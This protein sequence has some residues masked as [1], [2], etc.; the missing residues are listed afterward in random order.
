MVSE[1]EPKITVFSGTVARSS[2]K[3]LDQLFIYAELRDLLQGML[4]HLGV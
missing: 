3:Q 2:R 4:C 1:F